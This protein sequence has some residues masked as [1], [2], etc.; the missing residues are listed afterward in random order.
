MFKWLT[1]DKPIMETLM[2]DPSATETIIWQHPSTEFNTNSRVNLGLNE[3]AVFFDMYSGNYEIITKSTDLK[4]NNIPVLSRIPTA[5]T[6]GVSKY[7]CRVYFI[8]TAISEN[9]LWGTPRPLGP[10]YDGIHKGMTYSLVMNGIYTFQ[11]V[12]VNKLLQFV[13]SD[14][15][16][17]FTSFEENRVL[18]ILTAQIYKLITKVIQTLNLDFIL[19]REFILNCSDALKNSLQSDVLDNMGMRIC[20]F[21]INDVSL[22]DDPDDPYKRALSSM[23]EESAMVQGLGIQGIQNYIL[24]HGVR[25]AEMSAANYGAA[26]A[27][28]GIGIGA[29][30]GAGIG[31]QLGNMINSVMGAAQ[32]QTMSR[33]SF[34][35]QASNIPG[36]PPLSNPVNP[37]TS[38][39]SPIDQDRLVK[40]KQLFDLGIITQSQY[41]Q[42]VAEILKSL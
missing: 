20:N 11:V 1:G 4:T 3:V 6:G 2:R 15:T 29:G 35:P 33:S 32:P 21:E 36:M 5:M 40:L 23:T 31:G 12:D 18:G 34:G 30:V 39:S 10:F 14:K 19:S 17:D 16:I 38:Q 24:T 25:V 8:R 27:M 28:T 37:Q 26:G 7:Q 42:K 22:P 13:D 41:D 9:L